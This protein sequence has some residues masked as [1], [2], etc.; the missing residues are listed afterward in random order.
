MPDDINY[1]GEVDAALSRR[2]AFT[3]R[4]LSVAVAL[5]MAALLPLGGLGPHRRSDPCR[6]F[7]GGFPAHAVGL[8][9]GR[10]HPAGGGCWGG[11]G[12]GGERGG[13]GARWRREDGRLIVRAGG[14]RGGGPPRAIRGREAMLRDEEPV[15]PGDLRA[16]LRRYWGRA[17]QRL[18]SAPARRGGPAEYLEGPEPRSCRPNFPCW[19]PSMPSARARWRSSWHARNSWTAALCWRRNSGIRPSAC[20]CAT[21]IPAWIIWGW[22]EDHPDP[23]R[24]RHAGRIHPQGTGHDGGGPAAH[25]Q[26]GGRGTAGHQ[27]GDNKRRTELGSVRESLT[28]GGA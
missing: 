28:A 7:R 26:P 10:R 13:G 20:C 3:A 23:G 4:A 8:Q 6:R 24:D 25:R 11:R 2:P 19:R 18:W 9:P 5:L 12:G 16:F 22:S 17:R 27:P 15:F 1:A 14:A 21:I